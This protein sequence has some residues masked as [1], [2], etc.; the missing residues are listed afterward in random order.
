MFVLPFV[1][2]GDNHPESASLRGA[3]GSATTLSHFFG[4]AGRFSAF[5]VSKKAT[6]TLSFRSILVVDLQ[7]HHGFEDWTGRAMTPGCLIRLQTVAE[8]DLFFGPSDGAVAAAKAGVLRVPIS[9]RIL[10]GKIPLYTALEFLRP[11]VFSGHGLYDQWCARLASHFGCRLLSTRC[12]TR[13]ALWQPLILPGRRRF[14]TD[15]KLQRRHSGTT[16]FVR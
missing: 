6:R 4:P 12:R 13:P 14:I 5:D 2:E 3:S 11:T 16:A 15:T 10:K 7:S 1:T 8:L 9:S